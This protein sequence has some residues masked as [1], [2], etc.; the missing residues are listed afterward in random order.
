MINEIANTIN[1]THICLN[2]EANTINETHICLNCEMA[3]FYRCSKRKSRI[4]CS[5]S[6][7]VADYENNRILC[8]NKNIT[9]TSENKLRDEHF[10]HVNCCYNQCITPVNSLKLTKLVGNYP[11][12]N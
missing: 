3:Q 6:C 5:K 8:D 11:F 4:Y 10:K 1:E 2:C 7:Q 9:Y 12:L